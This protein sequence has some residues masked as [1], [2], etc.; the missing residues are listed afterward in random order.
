MSI[1]DWRNSS[2]LLNAPSVTGNKP[3]VAE[4]KA[5]SH[6]HGSALLFCPER[7]LQT[8]R[9]CFNYNNGPDALWIRQLLAISWLKPDSV[10]GVFVGWCVYSTQLLATFSFGVLTGETCCSTFGIII[11][12]PLH[13]E[14]IHWEEWELRDDGC[15]T[16]KS[17]LQFRVP[18]LGEIGNSQRKIR[19]ELKVLMPSWRAY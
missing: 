11:K 8:T 3:S 12:Q 6:R 10:D 7:A 2:L 5:E 15:S 4:A 9:Q 16:R 13:K 14:F 17:I 1:Y 19:R 18:P